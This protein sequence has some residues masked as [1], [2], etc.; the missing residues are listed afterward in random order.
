MA[1]RTNDQLSAPRMEHSD[2]KEEEI[3]EE[4]ATDFLMNYAPKDQS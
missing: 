2:R 4:A 3:D 1:I